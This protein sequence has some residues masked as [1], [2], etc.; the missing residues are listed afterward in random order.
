LNV[1]TEMMITGRN[2][3]LVGIVLLAVATYFAFH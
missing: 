1:N 3:L 2:S